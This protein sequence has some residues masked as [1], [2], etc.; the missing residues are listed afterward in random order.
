MNKYN[1]KRKTYAINDPLG[2]TH[3]PASRDHYSHLKFVLFCEISKRVDRGKDGQT[4][5]WTPC[6]I[7]VILLPVIVDRSH[8]S[9]TDIIVNKLD[10][11]GAE[12]NE[13]KC[14]KEVKPPTKF[15]Q[16]FVQN[17]PP[18]WWAGPWKECE[19]RCARERDVFCIQGKKML[20]TIILWPTL[21]SWS[22]AN[23]LLLIPIWLLCFH[24]SGKSSNPLPANLFL[25]YCSFATS[26]NL[27]L[28][29][30]Q[31]GKSSLF[32]K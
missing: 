6:V 16:C 11:I 18:S 21:T 8:G 12:S 17:C 26:F 29:N 28:D 4:D 10:A 9:I 13:S 14:E 22:F 23:P 7:I 24:K 15:E 20:L 5:V 27:A 1:F 32:S 25:I 31:P 19:E 2:Q 3:S 30:Q